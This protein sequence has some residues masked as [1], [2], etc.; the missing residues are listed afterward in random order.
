[1]LRV[2]TIIITTIMVMDKMV[3]CLMMSS[4]FEKIIGLNL[5]IT[6][7]DIQSSIILPSKPVSF[8]STE[9]NFSMLAKAFI[10]EISIHPT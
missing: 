1:M 5:L 10:S 6:C 9:S 8:C 3:K 7:W 4:I 2:E